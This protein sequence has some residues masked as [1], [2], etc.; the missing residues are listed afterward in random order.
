[1]E[2]RLAGGEG[3]SIGVEDRIWLH[4]ICIARISSANIDE[5]NPRQDISN[6]DDNSTRQRE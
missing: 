5:L 2:V 6:A 1:M 3:D 4:A